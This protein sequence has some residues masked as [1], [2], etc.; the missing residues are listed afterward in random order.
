[1]VALPFAGAAAENGATFRERFKSMLNWQS[2][3][4]AVN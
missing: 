3:T 1:M 2:Q 4:P